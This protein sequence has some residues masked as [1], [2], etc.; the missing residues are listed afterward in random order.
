MIS[1][2]YRKGAKTALR[3]SQYDHLVDGWNAL[4]PAA[5]RER[6][7]TCHQYGHLWATVMFQG[8]AL[9]VVCRRCCAY[10]NDRIGI[11]QGGNQ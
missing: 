5:R 7:I 1:A 8:E 4:S 11:R 2:D 3:S 10:D 6:M 9:Y